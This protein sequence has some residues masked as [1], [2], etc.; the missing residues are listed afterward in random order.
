MPRNTKSKLFIPIA[1]AFGLLLVSA[2]VV[3]HHGSAGY[4]PPDKSV[5]LKGTVTE[6]KW[7]NPHGQIHFDVTDGNGDVVHWISECGPPLRLLDVGWTRKTLKPGDVVTFY[8]R[9]AKNGV[10]RAILQKL[11]LPDGTV[12]ENRA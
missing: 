10:P 7:S 2:P 4:E 8:V 3:A 6:F 12:L 1:I 5:T 11:V 9:V